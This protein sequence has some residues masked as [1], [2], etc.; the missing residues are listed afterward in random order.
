MEWILNILKSKKLWGWLVA[1]ALFGAGMI[2]LMD[3]V[4]MPEYTNYNEGVTVPDVTKISLEEAQDLLTSYNLRFEI[5][6]RRAHA[7]Y[8]ADYIIDQSPPARQIVKPNRKVYLTVNTAEQ[9]KAVVPDLVNMSF[10][11]ARI[12]LEN[13][14]L[15]LG[16][17]SYESSRFRNIVLWQSLAARDTVPKGSVVDLTISDGLGDKIVDVPDIVGLRLPE[18]QQELR[19]AGLYVDEIRF[20]PSRDTIPNIVLEFSPQLKKMREGESVSIV[21]SERFDVKEASET[22]AVN[23]DSLNVTPPDTLDSNNQK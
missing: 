5:A 12:Q 21:V 9:P 16:T 20:R 7:S 2:L 10:R 6:D 19:K 4:I 11:N 13:Y 18:A 17:V 3:K 1:L 22:G 23:V 8:P 14:G 15:Q